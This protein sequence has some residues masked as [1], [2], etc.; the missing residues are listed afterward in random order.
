MR[1]LFTGSGRRVNLLRY[2]RKSAERHGIDLEIHV[3]DT[4]GF[5][6]AWQVADHTH[7]V[8][9]ARDPKF[10]DEVE[11]ICADASVD[12]LIPLIDPE[13]PVLAAA[14]Q[15]VES[16]GTRLLLSDLETIQITS[17]K[18][19]T[20]DHFAASGIATVDTWEL[21]DGQLPPV[22]FPVVIKPRQG[23]GS[24]G[25]QVVHDK[26]ELA[27]F[28][29]RTKSP[30]VQPHMA[31]V[32]YTFDAWADDNGRI[33]GIVPRRRI[34]TRAGEMNKGVTVMDKEIVDQAK[35]AL[36]TLSGLRGPLN[37]Q[38][39]RDGEQ[40]LFAEVNPRF[41]GGFVLS[42]QAGAD[43]PG[44]IM[45]NHLGRDVPPELVTARSGVLALRFEDEFVFPLE[46]VQARDN[47]LDH[48]RHPPQ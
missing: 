47:V 39:F 4:N 38:A 18:L 13:L 27:F 29:P 14:R 9:P 42:Y 21:E 24:I 45:L 34:E 22:P 7:Q 19:S 15:R 43:F 25:V 16:T 12:L 46:D 11:Q 32:E 1:I 44:A 31:L 10:L 26:A 5:A 28:A 48:P 40:M 3:T 37:I 8:H 6:A 35:T 30:C 36:A 33:A 17:D 41:G 23:S 2:F 20:H